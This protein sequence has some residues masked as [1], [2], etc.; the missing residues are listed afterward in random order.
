MWRELKTLIS[1]IN[2]NKCWYCESRDMRS[3]NAVDHFR[4]KG[5]VARERHE[6]YWWLAF[7]PRNYRF[8][9]TFCNSRRV[10]EEGG[11]SGGKQDAFPLADGSKRAVAPDDTLEGE[12][13]VLLDPCC[14]PDTDLLWF[15]ETGQ[16]V[17]NPSTARGPSQALRVKT[18]IQLY[19]LDHVK[20]VESRRRVYLQVYRLIRAADRTYRRWMS[21]DEGAKDVYQDLLVQIRS[22]AVREAEHSATARCALLGYRVSSGAADA[23][24][25]FL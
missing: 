8:S 12:F 19:H 14:M 23:V 7:D 1:S 3:D 21:G 15:D 13:P 20:L 2:S 9:C 4:P 17:P 6:G 18:S 25:R 11:T 5:R 16:V 24:L 22:Q 10:D